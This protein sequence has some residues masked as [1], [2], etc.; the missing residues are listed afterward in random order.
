MATIVCHHALAWYYSIMNSE[1]AMSQ[2]RFFYNDHGFC[3]SRVVAAV[4]SAIVTLLFSLLFFASVENR[5]R[6]RLTIR[7]N[8]GQGDNGMCSAHSFR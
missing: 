5:S 4:L 3:I 2:L 1:F 7:Q 6:S 8:Q